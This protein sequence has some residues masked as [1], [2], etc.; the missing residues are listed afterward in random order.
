MSL[1]VFNICQRMTFGP[2]PKRRCNVQMVL[3][4]RPLRLKAGCLLTSAAP[5]LVQPL[6]VER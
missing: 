3:E 5:T 6:R 4:L 1:S 2:R